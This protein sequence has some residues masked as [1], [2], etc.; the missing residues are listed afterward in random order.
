MEDLLYKKSIIACV[1]VG[2]S[3][4]GH[5]R[6]E[7][8]RGEEVNIVVKSS[9]GGRVTVEP[10]GGWHINVD[11]PWSLRV[12]EAKLGFT[13]SQGSA[14]VAGAP[15][16]AGVI[17]GGVCSESQCRTFKRDVTVVP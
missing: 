13:L 12:G 14:S 9:A 6:G 17:R 2:L 10:T 15:S 16:G 4:G 1:L 8:A 3:I 11:Y 7:E 5:A